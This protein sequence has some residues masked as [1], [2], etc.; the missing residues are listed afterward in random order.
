MLRLSGDDALSVAAAAGLRCGEPYAVTEQDWALPAGPCPCRVIVA[1]AKRS[2]TG[3]ELVEIS[4]PGA[5]ALVAMAL[6]AV[7]AAG[8]VAA[9]PGGFTRQAL[10]RGRLRLDQAEGLLALVHSHDAPAA[11][12]ALTRL[13]GLMGE[14]M[15]QVRARLLDLRALVEAGLDFSD[16]ADVRPWDEAALRAECAALARRLARW[17]AVVA[18][19]G[20][21]PVVALCGAPNAGK[22][23][24][25]S[26][27]TGQPALVS[28]VPGTTR[29]CLEAPWRPGGLACTL[30]DTAG[31]L[32]TASGPDALAL[33][34]GAQRVAGAAVVLACAAPDAPLP[35]G[36]HDRLPAT[37]TV[38]E[39]ATKADLGLSGRAALAV[40]VHSGAGVERL[41]AQVA[42]CLAAVAPPGDRQGPQVAAAAAG[43]SALGAALPAD[44][45]LAEDLRLAA[46]RLG[47]LLGAT[48]SDEVLAAIFSRFCI[49]K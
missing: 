42:A 4:L 38:L 22:S 44:E 2:S 18:D 39:V 21:A 10:A 48:T 7:Q 16:E 24:L 31:W 20:G 14:D 35:A 25:F 27:L 37:A 49:G 1:S 11:A 15:Q 9:P 41:A 32:S 43:L 17:G 46:A 12:R 26:H 30:V 8:A 33:A 13:R 3:H 6:N 19:G 28:A 5:P 36:W 45:L 23:A 40:S 47:D 34:Q 29:D